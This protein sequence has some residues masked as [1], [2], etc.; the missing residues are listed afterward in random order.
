[1]PGHAHTLTLMK[2]PKPILNA[3]S[4]VVEDMAATVVDPDGNSVDFYAP[5][6]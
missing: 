3:L 2:T 6:T 4:I 5:S 1:M